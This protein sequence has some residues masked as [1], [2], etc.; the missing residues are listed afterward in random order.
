MTDARAISWF[1]GH[2]SKLDGW[3][4]GALSPA[5]WTEA[6]LVRRVAAAAWLACEDAQAQSE[7]VSAGDYSHRGKDA[8]AGTGSSLIVQLHADAA[9]AETGPDITRVFWFPKGNRLA[10]ELT[11]EEL[12]KVVPWKVEVQ[13]ATREK[14]PNVYFCLGLVAPASI[15]VELG[16]TDGKLGRVQLP[17]LTDKLGAALAAGALARRARG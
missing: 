11:A 12:A 14:W 16:F 17:L 5:G 8:M 6:W 9:P 1:P 15:L 13:E 10:A 3:D 7:I 2:G 4:P